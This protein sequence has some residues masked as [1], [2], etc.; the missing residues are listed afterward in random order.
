MS[1]ISSERDLENTIGNLLR[2]GV[3]AAA[4]VVFAGGLWILIS[5]GTQRVAYSP[6]QGEPSQLRNIS[7]II[8]GLFSGNGRALVQMGLLLLI[9]TPV[10]RV[11]LALIA[12]VLQRDRLYVVVTIIVLSALLFSLAGG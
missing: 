3:I 11:V 4:A 5:S 12:F 7:G 9:A 8:S 10:A 6:F 2:V 1:I